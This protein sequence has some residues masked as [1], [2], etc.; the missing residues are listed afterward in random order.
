MMVESI[1]V[2]VV[3]F[4]FGTGITGSGPF[5]GGAAPIA[6]IHYASQK[7]CETAAKLVLDGN[8]HMTS[9]RVAAVECMV[10]PRPSTGK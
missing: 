2:M 8:K 7:Q 9:F 1:W 5:T 3:W 10:V 4:G 6:D